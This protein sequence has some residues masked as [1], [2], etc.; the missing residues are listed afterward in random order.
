MGT[1]FGGLVIWGEDMR[2]GANEDDRVGKC[3]LVRYKVEG[4]TSELRY[5]REQGKHGWV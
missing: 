4:S 5:A 3:G 2:M 1:G